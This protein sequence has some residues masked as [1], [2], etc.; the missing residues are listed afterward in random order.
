[1]QWWTGE[2]L[3][4]APVISPIFV[5]L[6][7]S[8]KL[9]KALCT[10]IWIK[11]PGRFMTEK[12]NIPSSCHLNLNQKVW[13]LKYVI[14]TGGAKIYTLLI[15]DLSFNLPCSLVLYCKKKYLP[16]FVLLELNYFGMH[17]IIY[18]YIQ[19]FFGRGWPCVLHEHWWRCL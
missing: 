13:K 15:V 10:G 16:F 9:Y 17:F 7:T 14:N 4:T 8:T 1:M 3:P 5:Q 6:S 2:T 19:R 12:G 18:Q 11:R